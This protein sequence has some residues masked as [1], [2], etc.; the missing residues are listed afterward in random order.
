MFIRYGINGK[1][2]DEPL[3]GCMNPN[4][5]SQDGIHGTHA[6]CILIICTAVVHSRAL[7]MWTSHRKQTINKVNITVKSNNPTPVL[8][9]LSQ[10]CMPIKSYL[11]HHDEDNNGNTDPRPAAVCMASF[12][13]D[14]PQSLCAFSGLALALVVLCFCVN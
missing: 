6:R 12:V 10:L 5:F 9:P 3:C 7:Y 4:K 1:E 14:A 8:M 13:A 2:M 11:N